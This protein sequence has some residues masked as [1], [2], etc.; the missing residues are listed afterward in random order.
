MRGRHTKRL[1][2]A[3]LLV[4]GSL[5]AC[6]SSGSSQDQTWSNLTRV[7]VLTQT[8][9][10]PPVKGHPPTPTVYST[11]QQLKTVTRA[12]NAA[13]ISQAS[14]ASTSQGCAG[15]QQTRIVITAQGGKRTTLNAYTCAGNTTGDVAGNLKAFLKRIGGGG[16]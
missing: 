16:T 2:G 10:V 9:G 11:P 12:L 6:G 1:I 5:A 3:T 15:G 7:T 8:A 13:H 4:A 14:H